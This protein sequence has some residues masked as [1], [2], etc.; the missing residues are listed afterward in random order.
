MS[1]KEIVVYAKRDSGQEPYVQ[2]T[3][4]LALRFGARV[5]GVFPLPDLAM[6]RHMLD[7]ISD[8]SAVTQYVR[9]AYESAEL[10]E[11]RF[12]QY[13]AQ[14]SVECEWRTGEGDPAQVMVLAG[15]T[16]D[17]VVIEQRRPDL[18]QSGWDVP[19]EVA[20]SAGSPTLVIPHS[21]AFSDV[22]KRVLVAWNGS[23]DAAH[24]IGSA[25]PMLDAADSLVLLEGH[26]K[27]QFTTVTRRPLMHIRQRI[28][29]H[30]ANV[31]VVEFTPRW[32]EEGAGILGA[33]QEHGCDVIVMG[34][35]GH[36]RVRELLLG[37]ATRDV[38]REMQC[39]V[40]FAH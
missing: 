40:L 12:R 26:S 4:Q 36:S 2:I 25:M 31:E 7:R 23:R 20:L 24:A 28:E 35:Y 30:C 15:R 3:A 27:K 5:T 10:F 13:M 18:D 14:R 21:R 34:A 9:E 19:E 8:Q 17:L 39:P 1:W 22:G 37:G 29:A 33:A 16:A 6:M 32:G 11:I 38:L